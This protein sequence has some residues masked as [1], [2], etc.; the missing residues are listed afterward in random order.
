M[1]IAFI[2]HDLDAFSEPQEIEEML[3]RM[4]AEKDPP[5]SLLDQIHRL[6]KDLELSKELHHGD[7]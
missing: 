3:E 7:K 1:A 5:Q 6:E 4:R 2:M